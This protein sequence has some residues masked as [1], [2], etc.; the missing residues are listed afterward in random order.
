MYLKRCA[1]LFVLLVDLLVVPRSSRLGPL[2][3]S[4]ASG[5]SRAGHGLVAPAFAHSDLCL[6]DAG[7]QC[8]CICWFDFVPNCFNLFSI[9]QRWPSHPNTDRSR[10]RHAI[11]ALNS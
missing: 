9:S 4:P 1:H 3:L 5:W 2:F 7:L 11:L 8:V 10:V 6:S